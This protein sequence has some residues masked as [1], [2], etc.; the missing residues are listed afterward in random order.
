MLSTENMD[1]IV[2]RLPLFIN[3]ENSGRDDDHVKQ[4]DVVTVEMQCLDKD[5]YRF[6]ETLYD[7]GSAMANP[8]SNIKGG[9]LGCF[10]AYSFTSKDVVMEWDE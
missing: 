8:V 3:Y 10:G 4:G 9:A 5:A 7:V 1:G 2:I 6:F